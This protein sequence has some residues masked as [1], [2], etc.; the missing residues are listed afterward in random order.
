MGELRGDVRTIVRKNLVIY[1]DEF[2]KSL[3]PEDTNWDVCSDVIAFELTP[4]LLAKL[5]EVVEGV[6][7]PVIQGSGKVAFYA[8]YQEAHQAILKALE[9]K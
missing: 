6:E 9:E 7:P 2:S 5:R 1:G 4:L 3:E 8:G